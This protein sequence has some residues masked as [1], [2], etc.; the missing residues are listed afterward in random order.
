VV[1]EVAYDFDARH[2]PI[3][4][5]FPRLSGV[6]GLHHFTVFIRDVGLDVVKLANDSAK[7]ATQA[8]LWASVEK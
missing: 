6:I 1:V 3:I 7:F 5:I 8:R 2:A 4:G